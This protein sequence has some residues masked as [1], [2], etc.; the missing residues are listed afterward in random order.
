LNYKTTLLNHH[1]EVKK[2]DV[3]SILPGSL[4][5]EVAM[6]FWEDL[7]HK[8]KLFELANHDFVLDIVCKLQ[9][10]IYMQDDLICIL[11]TYA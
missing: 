6:T 8:V 4:L 1:K 10:N 7:V 9:P 5:K 3:L 2:F 11:D